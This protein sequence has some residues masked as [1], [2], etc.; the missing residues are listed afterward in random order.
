MAFAG[1][2]RPE[3]FFATLEQLGAEIVHRQAFADHAPYT[4]DTVMQLVE[5]AQQHN[6]VPVTTAKDHVRLPADARPMIECL[7]VVLQFAAP[8]AVGTFLR[9]R[10]GHV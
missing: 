8:D 1:I 5:A 6:A 9:E 7:R 4:P 3:K 10:L 2:G